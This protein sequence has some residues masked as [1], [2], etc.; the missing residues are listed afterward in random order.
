MGTSDV[1]IDTKLNKAVWAKGIRNVPYRIRVKLSR[2]RNEDEESANKLYT[3]VT[4]V[5]VESF[6]GTVVKCTGISCHAI[7]TQGW[8]LKWWT[9]KTEFHVCFNLS[10]KKCYEHAAC[11]GGILCGGILL[12][13]GEYP[14]KLYGFGEHQ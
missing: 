13:Q 5:L 12:C 7:Y 2:R 9:C 8:R 10:S 6:K 11:H 14:V 3:L 1:R 4:H